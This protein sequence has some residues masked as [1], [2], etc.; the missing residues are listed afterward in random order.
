MTQQNVIQKHRYS[1]AKPGR[2]TGGIATSG[3]VISAN[4]TE[5][6]SST[7]LHRS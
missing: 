5:A 3:Q 7:V 4:K 2:S 1:Q 6:D